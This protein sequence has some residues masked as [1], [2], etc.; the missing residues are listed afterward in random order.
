MIALKIIA[1]ISAVL[2]IAFLV[3]V[4]LSQT[5]V[6]DCYPLGSRN[7]DNPKENRKVWGYGKW[8]QALDRTGRRKEDEP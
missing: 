2:G 6:D 3:A 1:G 7:G 4:V 5:G 8:R